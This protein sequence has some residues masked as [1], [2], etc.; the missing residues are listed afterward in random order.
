MPGC[1]SGKPATPTPNPRSVGHAAVRPD[2]GDELLGVLEGVP[3]T[4]VIGH[5]PRRI[6]AQ[7]QDVL[8]ARIGIAVEDGRELLARVA[9]ARQVR[10]GRQPG[11]ALDPHD[12]VVSPLARRAAGA[13]G[14]RHERGP[15]R[16]ELGDRL[17]EIVGGPVGLGR[18]ELEAEGRG[19]GLEDVLD[20]HGRRRDPS[21]CRASARQNSRNQDTRS[22][23]AAGDPRSAGRRPAGAAARPGPG[24]AARFRPPSPWRRPRSWDTPSTSEHVSHLGRRARQ[25]RRPCW[26]RR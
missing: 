22:R 17:E 10:D 20:M 4:V 7:G 14:H 25:T 18:E 2:E 24:V 15:E 1:P 23:P 9:D 8:D 5:R 16:L 19:P 13:V 6:A 11:L 21:A 26:I 12:Q 3:G